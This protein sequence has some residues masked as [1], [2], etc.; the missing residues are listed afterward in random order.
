MV[1]KNRFVDRSTVE[2][3]WLEFLCKA[4]K[5]ADRTGV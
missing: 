2:T 5:K 1:H 3:Y 4:L